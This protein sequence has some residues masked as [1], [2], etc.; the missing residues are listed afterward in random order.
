MRRSPR[1][2]G[3]QPGADG[4]LIT[5][6]SLFL[7]ASAPLDGTATAGNQFGLLRSEGKKKKKKKDASMH[8]RCHQ[9]WS[10]HDDAAAET[11]SLSAESLSRGG[12]KTGLIV[13][14]GTL[15]FSCQPNG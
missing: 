1:A 2:T 8:T 6:S 9:L 12:K 5:P 7:N 15:V 13:L 14:L 3:R 11:K 10:E 4:G